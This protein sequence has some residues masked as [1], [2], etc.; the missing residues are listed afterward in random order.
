MEA[1]KPR[2]RLTGVDGN[3]FVIIGV[4]RDCLKKAGQDAQAGEFVKRAMTSMSYPDVLRLCHNY[5]DVR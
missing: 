3:V 1:K 5:V 4:V 2:C